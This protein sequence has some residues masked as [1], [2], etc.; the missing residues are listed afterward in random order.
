MLADGGVIRDGYHAELDQLRSL[1]KNSKTYLAAVETRER[2]RT[3]I[4]SLKVR[5]NRVFGY[6]I[7]ISKANL[8]LVPKDYDRKQT[9]VGAERFVTPELKEYEE[10][11]LTAEEQM[12]EIEK[13]LFQD[14]FG[15][16]S[17]K[18]RVAFVK[19]PRSSPNLMC[20]PGRPTPTATASR[21]TSQASEV[22]AEGCDAKRA[23][24]EARPLGRWARAA[25]R[26][27]RGGLGSAGDLPVVA[28]A[29]L[30]GAV[31]SLHHELDVLGG[32]GSRR[33]P[34]SGLR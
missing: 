12:L 22:L 33:R 5:F 24:L 31:A 25:D 21:S 3:G 18:R 15:I 7:E 20:S 30:A 13:S 6:Y 29:Q 10:K 14:R 1:S 16:R 2:E 19:L 23:V 27:P 8:H 26:A 9:L 17:P 34:T 32:P 11:I 4:G 28:E